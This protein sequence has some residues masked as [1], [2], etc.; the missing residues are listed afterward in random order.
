[1]KNF[2]FDDKIDEWHESNSELPLYEYLG[3]TKEEYVIWLKSNNRKN[4]KKL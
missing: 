3:L 4:I 2:D 1:M